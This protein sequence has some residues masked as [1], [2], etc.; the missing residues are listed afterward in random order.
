M[1]TINVVFLNFALQK[2]EVQR[3]FEGRVGFVAVTTEAR[4]L[5]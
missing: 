1:A 3:V 4:C 5:M 2:L